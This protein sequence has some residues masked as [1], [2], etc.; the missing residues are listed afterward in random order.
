MNYKQSLLAIV[1][2]INLVACGSG[3]IEN[4]SIPK[5][6]HIVMAKPLVSDSLTV[7]FD[8]TT[9]EIGEVPYLINN[10][11]AASGAKYIVWTDSDKQLL[12][13]PSEQTKNVLNLPFTVNQRTNAELQV[14]LKANINEE[15]SFHYKIDSGKWHT[16]NVDST[17]DWQSITVN[18]FTQLS[19]GEH[20]LYIQP[21]NKNLQLDN[22]TLNITD[23]DIARVEVEKAPT[24]IKA[25]LGL[26][27]TLITESP[28]NGDFK[29]FSHGQ[30]APLWLDDNDWEGVHLAAE[31]LQADIK[32]VGEVAPE[33][34]KNAEVKAP[35]KSP[36][37]IGTIGKSKLIDTLIASG[38]LNVSDIKDQWENFVI[39]TVDHPMEGVEQALV[40]VGSDKRGTIFGMYELS[41]QLGVSPWYWWADVP[42]KK[43]DN[44]YVVKGRYESGSPRVKYRGIFLN[45]EAPALTGWTNDKFGGRNSQFYTKVFELI[46]HREHRGATLHR[47]NKAQYSFS[48]FSVVRSFF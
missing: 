11:G 28:N 22:V 31:N 24:K 16:E 8:T 41:E 17:A 21:G 25:H 14:R 1:S 37:I 48:V 6:N 19:H 20:T 47:E 36:I 27:D 18:T 34:V 40:I 3:S 35:S 43:R 4:S 29:M 32:R 12:T 30:A 39:T 45:D 15:N 44:A 10:D 5:F 26:R 42:T 46:I 23:G 38:K 33:Y 9:N 2:S 7:E 13:Q